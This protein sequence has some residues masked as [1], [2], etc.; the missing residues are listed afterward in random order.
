M[1]V[2]AM[3]QEMQAHT[4]ITPNLVLLN[5]ENKRKVQAQRTTHNAQ[6]TT[7]HNTSTQRKAHKTQAHTT[8]HK[9][10]AQ[11]IQHTHTHTRT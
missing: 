9:Q 10:H 4:T 11:H 1:G 7:Q 5:E 8:Q 3:I 6:R 2:D